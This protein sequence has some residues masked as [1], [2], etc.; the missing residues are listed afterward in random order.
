MTDQSAL[1]PG[2]QPRYEADKALSSRCF[3]EETVSCCCLNSWSSSLWLSRHW[4]AVLYQW[5]S[6]LGGPDS[7]QSCLCETCGWQN[8]TGM[9]FSQ[10]TS[11]FCYWISF[12]QCSTC[13]YLLLMLHSLRY[14]WYHY[15]KHKKEHNSRT[16]V[17][18]IAKFRTE[19]IAKCTL[20]CH[21]CWA[22]C[23]K[24]QTTLRA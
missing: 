18:T 23:V 21:N 9:R 3:G 17:P 19:D 22:P 11:I 16:T 20:Q 7:I 8:G 15:I 24:L 4:L 12:H 6:Q 14:W 13:T 10:H 2:K 1:N 5:T